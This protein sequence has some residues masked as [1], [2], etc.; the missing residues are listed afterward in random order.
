MIDPATLLPFL[1][2]SVL[3]TV[4]PGPNNTMALVSGVQVGVLG[5]VPLVCGIAVG[6]ALQLAAIGFGLGALLEAYPASQDVLRIGG[7]LYLVWLAWKIAG[8]G[9]VRID[10]EGH[11][12]LGFAGAAAFQWINPKAWA[13]TTSAAAAYIP[14]DGY[15]VNILVASLVL[16]LVAL[17]CVGVWTAAGSILRRLLERPTYARVFNCLVAA[18]LLMTTLPMLLDLGRR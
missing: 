10:D 6:V 17:P 14:R 8:S 12:P 1:L 15:V 18:L 16:A 3:L 5:S 9:P 13:I 11:R 7:S 4:T 2:F